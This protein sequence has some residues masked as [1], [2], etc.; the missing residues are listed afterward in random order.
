[1]L[2]R[3]E[4]VWFQQFQKLASL[5]APPQIMENTSVTREGHLQLAG[6]AAHVTIAGNCTVLRVLIKMQA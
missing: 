1:M 2:E 3:F 5:A 6:I 4:P